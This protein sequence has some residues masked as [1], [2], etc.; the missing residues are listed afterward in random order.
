MSV[1]LRRGYASRD[2][3]FRLGTTKIFNGDDVPP[4]ITLPTK[5]DAKFRVCTTMLV[6]DH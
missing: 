2:A 6:N 4:T 5:A 3:K 1:I